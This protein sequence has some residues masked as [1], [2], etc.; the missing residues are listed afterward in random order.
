MRVFFFKLIKYFECI[1][2]ESRKGKKKVKV[3]NYN[4]YYKEEVGA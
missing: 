2:G 4:A 1:M 3:G